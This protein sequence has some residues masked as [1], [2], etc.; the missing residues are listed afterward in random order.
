MFVNEI[1]AEYDLEP[2][3]DE[4]NIMDNQ[5]WWQAKSQAAMMAQQGGEEGEGEGGE[6][7]EEGAA[8]E[9]EG[10]EAEEQEAAEAPFGAMMWGGED[11]ED[12]GEATEKGLR[13]VPYAWSLSGGR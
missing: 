3:P 2:V 11:A 4:E 12:A 8:A 10:G 7:G 6:E 9:G 5:I 1:R 13:R